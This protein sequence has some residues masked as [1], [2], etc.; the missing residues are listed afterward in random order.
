M[1][2]RQFRNTQYEVSDDGRVFSTDYMHTGEKREL[3]Y[4]LDKDGYYHVKIHIDGKPKTPT[5]HSLVCE[6]FLGDRNG[7]VINH[8]NEV[9][10]DNRVSNLEYCTVAYNNNYGTRQQRIS[11]ALTNNPK[12]SYE[13]SQYTLDGKLVQ[14]FPS[15]AEAERQTKIDN[16]NILSCCNGKYQQAN[17]YVWRFGH[18]SC[19]EVKIEYNLKNIPSKSKK[20]A[21]MDMQ[22]NIIQIFPSINEVGRQLGIPIPNI[23]DCC[24]GR[25]K[26]AHKY[27]W[28]YVE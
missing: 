10:T 17:G 22:G 13:V 11:E 14:T 18:E 9:K 16:S 5:V 12:L 1:E 25:R 7:R 21:Q 15:S 8:K 6:C 23:V 20:V 24:K 4:K 3:T 26:S 19:I 2:I 27:K 28:K